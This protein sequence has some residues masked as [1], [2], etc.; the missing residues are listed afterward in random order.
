MKLITID[1]IND[2]L[3]NS[4]NDYQEMYNTK[5]KNILVSSSLI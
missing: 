2:I 3:E 5:G 4:K 1:M